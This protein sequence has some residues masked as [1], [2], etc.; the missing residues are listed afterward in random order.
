MEQNSKIKQLAGYI[1][2][3]P[4]DSFSKFA[5]AL[6]FLKQNELNR[7]RILFED[8]RKNDPGYLG[9][10]YHLGRLYERLEQKSKALETYE[11]GLELAK[12]QNEERTATELEEVLG[13][14]KYEMEE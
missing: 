5:L 12:K 3:N 10:Y 7:S 1:K 14:L 2:K 11:T 13:E 4:S 8:I 9:V 6:E